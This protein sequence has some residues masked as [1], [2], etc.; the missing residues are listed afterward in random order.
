MPANRTNLLSV[1]RAILTFGFYVILLGIPAVLIVHFFGGDASGAM[2]GAWA[3]LPPEKKVVATQ[4][5]AARQVVNLAL[6]LP[7]VWL[8]RAIVDS[9]R[10]GDPFVPGNAARLRRI[11]WLVV[12]ANVAHILASPALPPNFRDQSA[13]YPGLVTILLVFVLARIFETG[14]RMRTEIQETI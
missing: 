6:A 9:A 12:A 8:L 14:S 13:G 11:G 7:I 1:T 10:S 4:V 5:L 3:D 2:A